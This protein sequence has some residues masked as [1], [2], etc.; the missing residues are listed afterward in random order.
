MNVND[1]RFI[2][3]DSPFCYNWKPWFAYFPVTTISG[4][5]IWWKKIY[6]RN[7]RIVFDINYE[8]NPV[9]DRIQ[10]G[11]TFDLIANPYQHLERYKGDPW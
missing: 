1:I 2:C 10:Y 8:G 3:L 11:T 6:K 7:I 5:R 4:K 9:I